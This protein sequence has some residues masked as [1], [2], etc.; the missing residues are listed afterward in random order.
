MTLQLRN[1]RFL[2]DGR[3]DCE[4]VHPDRGWIPFTADPADPEPHGRSVHVALL[5]QGNIAPPLPPPPPDP[6]LLAA[7]LRARRT[8][9]LAATDW[10][11][12]PDAQASMSPDQRSAWTLYRQALRDLPQQE[13]FP[14]A[15]HWPD[16]PADLD[17]DI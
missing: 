6:D 16:P 7:A 9:H 3:I 2:E 17:Q 4:I 14:Q 1:P 12:L 15:P 11:Q 10:T 5:L 8:A 13:G